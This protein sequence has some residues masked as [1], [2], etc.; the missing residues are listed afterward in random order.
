V[1]LFGLVSALGACGG[2]GTGPSDESSDGEPFRLESITLGSRHTCGLTP[3]GKAYCWGF[4]EDGQLGDGSTTDRSTPVAVAG[5]LTFRTLQAGGVHNCGITTDGAI[6]CWG[7]NRGGR[8]GDGTTADRPFPVRVAGSPQLVSLSIGGSYSCGLTAA[9]GAYCWGFNFDGQFGNGKE[10]VEGAC[11][12]GD[13]DIPDILGIGRPYC[14]RPVPA[15]YGLTLRTL[16]PGSHNACGLTPEGK[17]Y[18]WGSNRTG[19]VGDGTTTDR[20]TPAPVASNLSYADLSGEAWYACALRDDGVADCWGH[21]PS[22]YMGENHIPMGA[23]VPAPLTGLKLRSV[24]LGNQVACGLTD[25]GTTQCWGDH[26]HGALGDGRM[27][28]PLNPNDRPSMTPR[29]VLGGRIFETV[30]ANFYRACGLM[31]DRVAYCWG[32]NNYGQL[33]DGTRQDRAEPVVVRAAP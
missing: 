8:L 31:S 6:W 24:S 1:A 30:V 32:M 28:D 20:L 33:G 7:Y 19:Q 26:L 23:T 17:A 21:L 10:V 2:D 14:T 11:V 16:E 13:P 3:A 15:A 27:R 29:R 18:C 12:V 22:A 9:G 4:N 25:D 5:D